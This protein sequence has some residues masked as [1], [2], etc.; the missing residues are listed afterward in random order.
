[1]V[2][3]AHERVQRVALEANLLGQRAQ[4]LEDDAVA[5]VEEADQAGAHGLRFGVREPLVQ[6]GGI[7]VTVHAKELLHVRRCG[8]VG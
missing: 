6:L 5:S 1:M 7:V 8:V 2:L 3:L 4:Q